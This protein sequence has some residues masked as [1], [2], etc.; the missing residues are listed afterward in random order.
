MTNTTT[1]AEYKELAIELVDL[2]VEH[3]LYWLAESGF[4]NA[5][6]CSDEPDGWN[7]GGY[8][9]FVYTSIASNFDQYNSIQAITNQPQIG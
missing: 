2:A 1:E 7:G 8:W 3:K 4:R 6:D 5:T 9:C